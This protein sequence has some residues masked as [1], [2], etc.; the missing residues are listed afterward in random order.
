MDHSKNVPVFDWPLDP[1]SPGRE[2]W[3][4]FATAQDR[5]LALWYRYTLVSTMGDHQEARC[6]VAVSDGAGRLSTFGTHAVP[7]GQ[8]TIQH[9]PFEIAVG[10]AGTIRDGRVTGR[11]ETGPGTVSWDLQHDPDAVTFTPLRSPVLTD[12][13][14]RVL[15]TGHHWSVNQSVRV[16]GTITV[17]DER[18]EVS[19]GTGHQGHTVGRSTPDRWHWVHCNGFGDDH[20]AVEALD[21]DGTLSVCLRT[22]ERTHQLNRVSHLAGPFSNRTVDSS[23]GTWTFLG[24]GDGAQVRC[25]VAADSAHWQRAAYRCPDDS[26]RYNA[27]CSLSYVELEYRTNDADGWSDW[28]QATSDTGRAEWVDSE[29]PI[30]GQYLPADWSIEDA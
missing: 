8:V 15:G 6:W 2:V 1:G 25:R 7:L 22:A 28:Q 3:Y 26:R 9:T 5:P 11:V 27:H 20:L 13:A 24:R 14:S 16:S 4:G 18:I 12:L 29:P 17:G 21:L 10:T 23:P 30:D 19:N